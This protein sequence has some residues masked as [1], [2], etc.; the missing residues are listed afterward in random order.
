MLENVCL[1]TMTGAEHSVISAEAQVSKEIEARVLKCGFKD[2]IPDFI[3]ALVKNLAHGLR[4]KVVQD[5][6]TECAM[7]AH[8]PSVSLRN[9]RM[10]TRRDP[11]PLFELMNTP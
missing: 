3:V 5:T 2:Q 10:G 8:T 4:R 6:L 1:S 9:G 7:I 11:P